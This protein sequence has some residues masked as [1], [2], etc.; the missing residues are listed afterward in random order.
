MLES[1]G[2]RQFIGTLSREEE[3]V[4]YMAQ[5]RT[6]IQELTRISDL[7]TIWAFLDILVKHMEWKAKR[8]VLLRQK[9]TNQNQ[10]IHNVIDFFTGEYGQREEILSGMARLAAATMN[11][12]KEINY[13]SE[14]DSNPINRNQLIRMRQAWLN[15]TIYK[16]EVALDICKAITASFN[17]LGLQSER[18]ENEICHKI[19]NFLQNNE[20]CINQSEYLEL[21][22]T[23][24]NNL[25]GVNESKRS[26]IT[27]ILSK[28]LK[29][30]ILSSQ[31]STRI[32][33]RSKAMMSDLII[34]IS[35]LFTCE[36][37]R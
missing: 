10:F 22:L 37:S 27:K 28:L 31:T 7:S 8:K 26:E 35:S 18:V 14:E 36:P 13:F 24:L 12:L 32:S 11:Y 6:L 9:K 30:I 15:L 1:Q 23:F 25:E 19:I 2:A 34:K 17:L 3:L 33:Y 29:T 5:A 4:N 20:N 21:L 16:R